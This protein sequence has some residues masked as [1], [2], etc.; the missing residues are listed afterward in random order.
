MDRPRVVVL[1][2]D[3]LDP[4]LLSKWMD[5][6]LL[7]TFQGLRENGTFSPLATTNP[8]ETAAAW[9]AFA[10]GQNPGKTGIF[11]FVTR[12]PKSYAVI[13]AMVALKRLK[14]GASQGLTNPRGGTSVWTLLGERGVKSTVLNL[15]VTWPPEQF[16]GQMLSGMGTP[17]LLMTMGTATY[18]STELAESRR[19]FSIREVRVSLENGV[20]E[21]SLKGP[22][23]EAV[24]LRF[25]LDKTTAEVTVLIQGQRATVAQRAWSDWLEVRFG[26]SESEKLG[27]C[28]FCALD[29]DGKLSIYCSPMQPHPA[30]PHLPISH[31]FGYA[32][33]LYEELG[34]FRT[35]GREVDIFNLVSEVLSEDVLLADTFR[36][37][38][39]REQL[40]LHALESGDSPLLFS[41]WG[42][43][44]TT[45]HGYWRFTDPGHP[46]YVEA[47]AKIFA[48]A[49]LRVYQEA[50]AMVSRLLKSAPPGTILL[51]ASDH[52]CVGWRRSVHFNTWLWRE[53]FLSFKSELS[54]GGSA[55][56]LRDSDS[57]TAGFQDVDWSKTRAYAVGCGKI[58][59]NLRGREGQG[60][61]SPGSERKAVEDEISQRLMQ[62]RDP[63]DRNPVVS[64]VYRSRDVQ[65]GPKMSNAPDLIVGL[66]KGYRVSWMMTRISLGDPVVDNNSKLGGDHVS[67][68]HE[69][70]PGSLLSNVRLDLE[71]RRPHILDIAPTLMQIYGLEVS[72]D[73]DGQSIWPQKAA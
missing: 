25:E 2:L 27:L 43:V 44:D 50:D 11:D 34:P 53:G 16:A 14:T 36:S 49:I 69:L 55:P 59:L 9:A 31:P 61:V 65:W 51:I 21:T 26:E 39:E 62:L 60:I 24:P 20:A 30:R 68:D 56:Q 33:R 18:Y 45:Q 19:R 5:E 12:D 3:G 37:M 71:N 32:Q 22:G 10:T 70:V 38:T 42:Q 13:P 7:P 64:K 40:T 54:G 48:D 67:V 73:M 17:D 52:G 23:E 63:I 1:A 35:M 4:V 58:Y 15:P 72:P 28:R 57:E 66:H 6:S 29:L 47:E 8:P 41:W 46:L